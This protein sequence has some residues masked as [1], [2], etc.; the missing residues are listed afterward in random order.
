VADAVDE[1]IAAVDL[2]PPANIDE[3]FARSRNSIEYFALHGLGIVIHEA[4]IELAIA[5]LEGEAQY[6]LLT[7]ANRA[8][9]TT[10]VG[11][12]HMHRILFKIG[13]PDR[14]GPTST[15]ETSGCR[16]STGRST[17]RR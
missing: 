7:W 4:Q 2:S 14:H 8:G 6:L 5:T 17:Q 11:I 3:L 10:I 1:A 13:V 9:K 12:V 16:S 15:Y